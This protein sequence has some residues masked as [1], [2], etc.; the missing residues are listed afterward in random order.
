F[1]NVVTTGFNDQ[2]HFTSTDAAAILP[3]DAP[4]VNGAGSFQATMKTVSSNRTITVTDV[5]NNSITG[6]SGGIDVTLP[7][8]AT[9]FTVTAAASATAGTPIVVSVQALDAT[10]TP[11]TNYAGM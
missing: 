7:G 5:S 9:H 10:N 2:V 8:P 3:G 6:T 11:T 1:N 4:L